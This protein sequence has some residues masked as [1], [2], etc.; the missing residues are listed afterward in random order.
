MR[1]LGECFHI[2]S[3]FRHAFQAHVEIE[4]VFTF[5]HRIFFRFLATTHAREYLLL[6]LACLI[7]DWS[8]DYLHDVEFLVVFIQHLAH[9]FAEVAFL[10]LGK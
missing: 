4:T 6:F 7:V 10:T 2:P 8:D 3:L 1:V 5:V 9:W